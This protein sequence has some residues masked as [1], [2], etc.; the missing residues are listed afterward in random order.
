MKKDLFLL[1]L[2]VIMVCSANDL[3]AVYGSDDVFRRIERLDLAPA[4]Q[5]GEIS[6]YVKPHPVI[7]HR[8]STY[9]TPEETEAA[10]RWARN[11]GADYLEL[12]LQMTKDSVLIA[13]HDV[14]LKRTTNIAQVFPGRENLPVS[15]FTLKELRM[16][17]AG[18]WFN[19]KNPDRACRQ[20]EGQKIT[21]LEEVV[22][23]AEG[24]C[25]ERDGSGEPLRELNADG[26]WDGRYSFKKDPEDNGN[27]PG[28]YVETKNPE[29]FPGIEKVLAK[30]L[31]EL[32]WLTTG[33][34]KL[35]ETH[36][37]RVDVA[38]TE[39]RV[40]LQTFSRESAVN[41][42]KYL[43]GIPKCFLISKGSL[44]DTTRQALIDCIDFAVFNNF[45]FIGPSI[46]GPPNNYYDFT[47]PWMCELYH[48]AGLIIH[49]Y[50]FDT[51]SQLKEYGG[52]Y[53]YKK[54]QS[55][56]DN[57]RRKAKDGYIPHPDMFIDG[58]FTNRSDL[59]LCYQNRKG[60]KSAKAVLK[61]LG[62]TN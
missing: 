11:I 58:G 20:F 18:S 9:W 4:N 49:A 46:G 7:A 60:A 24:Y 59:S 41:L 33:N 32:G 39:G 48:Q 15:A 22:K 29:L 55:F 26:I 62:Y 42:E 35:I 25:I 8:G 23:I 5:S 52:D 44:K 21:T 45:Q 37:G 16:L 3:F 14:N 57:P 43:S 19:T 36:K 30:Q 53:F 51:M 27:R 31:N 1:S 13:L 34:P 12:D 40:I 6:R 17:D 56:F 10:Y 50:S 38:N 2:F 61:R 28:I 54:D 47:K